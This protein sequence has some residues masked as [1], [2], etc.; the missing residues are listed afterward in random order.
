MSKINQLAQAF[1]DLLDAK[2]AG[3]GPNEWADLLQP[4]IDLSPFY[5]LNSLDSA[6]ITSATITGNEVFVDLEVPENQYWMV[7]A[8]HARLTAV[9]A[10]SRLQGRLGIRRISTET[11]QLRVTVAEGPL[12][13]STPTGLFN[14]HI[15]HDFAR[16]LWLKSGD[17]IFCGSTSFNDVG[18]VSGLGQVFA[19]IARVG[20]T[21][22]GI[23]A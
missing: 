21:S 20:P 12:V 14:Q 19:L 3:R 8:A 7:F 10:G 15:G 16:P 11:G 5:W 2:T 22:R 13:T 17:A 23:F 18:E 6:G 9:T 4:T 1:L